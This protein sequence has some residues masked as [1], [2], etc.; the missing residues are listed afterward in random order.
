MRFPEILDLIEKGSVSSDSFESLCNKLEDRVFG[1]KSGLLPSLLIEIGSIPESIN[2]DSSAEKLFAKAA[3]I[4][5]ARSLQELGLQST[6]NKRRS[7]CADVIAKSQFHEYSLV[8]DA[9]AF[10]LSRTAKNQKDF[11]VKSMSDW[12]G[13]HDYAVLVCPY[14]QYPKKTSQIYGQAI[15]H[16]VCLL[17]WEHLL[18][19]LKAGVR[20][21]TTVNLSSVWSISKQLQARVTVSRKNSKDNFHR[22]GNELICDRLSLAYDDL[23]SQ[24]LE[25]KNATISRAALE[26]DFW[27]RH[28]VEV[29]KYTRAQAIAELVSALKVNEKI[30]SITKFA[31]QLPKDGI[32]G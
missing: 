20:E 21:S 16:N 28:A 14:V 30:A 22:V 12:R 24:L 17:S 3:D 8:A 13:D 4:I 9:K 6:V 18:F 1:M 32:I 31:K 10:R 27:T 25:C 5:L 2:H 19:L 29:N 23:K 11:K 26:I 15:D 7:D